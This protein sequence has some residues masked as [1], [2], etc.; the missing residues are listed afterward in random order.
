[1]ADVAIDKKTVQDTKVQRP[2]KYCVVL[3]NDDYTPIDFV[4][5]VLTEVFKHSVDKAREI[6]W[7]VHDNGHGVVGIYTH[8]V[9]THKQKLV[10]Q[11]ASACNHPLKC[12]VEPE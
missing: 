11:M 9:A 6:M 4:T 7:H 10:H 1:M 2:K 5:C 8:E 12:E 3:C